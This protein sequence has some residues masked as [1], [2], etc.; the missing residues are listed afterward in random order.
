MSCPKCAKHRL[1]NIAV[2]IGEHHVTMHS[3]SSCG[4][5]WWEQEGARMALPAVL[6]LA[7]SHR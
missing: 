4:E 5:R 3:C 6:E 1:I 2:T 7:A